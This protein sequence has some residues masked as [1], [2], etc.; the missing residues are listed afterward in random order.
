M[1]RSCY[2]AHSQPSFLTDMGLQIYNQLDSGSSVFQAAIK[3]YHM[4]LDAEP[5]IDPKTGL[6]RYHPEGVGIPP[7]TE[8]THFTHIL[9]L[10]AAKHGLSINEFSAQYN[11]E[12]P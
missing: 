12:T 2:L 5:R 11:S 9:E 10:Y 4:I 3:E 7:E 8:A 6:S 1:A